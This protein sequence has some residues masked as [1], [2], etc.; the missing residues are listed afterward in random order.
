M[1]LPSTCRTGTAAIAAATTLGLTRLRDDYLAIVTL[2]F[3]EVLRTIAEKKQLD[4]QLKAALDAAVKQFAADFTAKKSA[5][6]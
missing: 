6:A 3:A 1:V 4:D 2:G 5:V